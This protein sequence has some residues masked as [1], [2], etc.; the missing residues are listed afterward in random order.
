MVEYPQAFYANIKKVEI[1]EFVVKKET[2]QHVTVK[3]VSVLKTVK[4]LVFQW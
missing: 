4:G 2:G 1:A 3:A